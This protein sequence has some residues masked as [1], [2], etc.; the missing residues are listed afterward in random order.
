MSIAPNFVTAALAGLLAG[1]GALALNV[2]MHYLMARSGTLGT[3]FLVGAAVD[4]ILLFQL[5]LSR[6]VF[7]HKLTGSQAQR[8]WDARFRWLCWLAVLLLV[9]LVGA[10]LLKAVQAG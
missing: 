10:P 2:W 6:L 3:P 5:P 9:Y 7:D 8:I 4:F 1:I